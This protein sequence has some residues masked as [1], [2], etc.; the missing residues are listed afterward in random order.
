MIKKILKLLLLVLIVA[1]IYFWRTSLTSYL[2]NFVKS[3]EKQTLELINRKNVDSTKEAVL[4]EVKNISET[5]GALKVYDKIS[6]I[7]LTTRLTRQ[8]I[9]NIANEERTRKGLAPLIE[10]QKLNSSAL[11]KVEDMMDL[12]YFEHVSPKGVSVSDLGKTVNYDFII[13]GENLAMGNFADDRD[14]IDAWMASPGHRAN[15][16]NENYTEIGVSIG[17]GYFDNRKVWF[18]VQHFG[19]P[20]DLCPSID[21]N[22]KSAITSL[23]KKSSA[24]QKT[25]EQVLADIKSGAV[26]NNKTTNEQIVDYNKIVNDYNDLVNT[27]KKN[28]T[29]YNKQVNEFNTCIK[30]RQ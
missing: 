4:N 30:E 16:L 6:P 13:I 24:L 3:T 27:I 26:I 29:I 15:I 18:A 11:I 21:Q 5:P 14:L 8:G 10:N 23:Q 28:I 25:L 20:K 22:L 17:K 19:A 1:S 2:N 7:D 9:I 12:Q